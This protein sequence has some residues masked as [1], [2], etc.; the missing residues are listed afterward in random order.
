MYLLIVNT[1]KSWRGGERQ[2][3][4]NAVGFMQQG[5]L[6]EL[7]CRQGSPL[8][9]QAL[10]T[11]IK[12]HEVGGNVETFWWLARNASRYDLIQ[13]Q[14]AKSQTAAVIT[15]PFHGRPV[16]YTRRVNFVPRGWLTKLK[17]KKTDC[18][19]A[20]SYSVKRV[21]EAFGIRN[22]HVI[23]DV[24]VPRL[25]SKQRAEKVYS[26]LGLA[27]KKI[28]ATIAALDQDKDPFTMLQAIKK[29]SLLRSDFVF[30]HFGDG[31]L[32][33][34]LQRRIDELGLHDRY[35]LMGFV[36]DVEDMFALMDLFCISSREE[37]LCSSVLD[38]FAYH[39]PVVSTKAGG[40]LELVEG[41]GF[42]CDTGDSDGI[43]LGIDQI[44]ENP[45]A[46]NILTD[47]AY[48]YVVSQHSLQATTKQYLD[49]FRL[50]IDGVD[51]Y[52]NHA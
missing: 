3:L 15:K 35:I 49:L 31:P 2:T 41:R 52:D 27:S 20:I 4:H 22:V 23:Y 14:T 19:V 47:A 38:A 12:V 51:K 42:L 36:T 24:V 28:V 39:V 11:G 16:V 43:A 8:V 50:L 32:R 37:G 33:L 13:A 6:V 5:A 7:L 25:L 45:S 40:L 46:F 30:L 1:E 10:A 34:E 48:R 18:V 26:R 17:Y 44:L 21:L 9:D 29:L